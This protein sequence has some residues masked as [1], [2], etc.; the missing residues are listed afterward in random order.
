MFLTNL[1]LFITMVEAKRY[2]SSRSRSSS[3]YCDYG[4]VGYA[5]DWDVWFGGTKY[6]Y[7]QGYEYRA[8]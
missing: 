6:C 8:E 3:S 7:V 5:P 1:I 4:F 2:S